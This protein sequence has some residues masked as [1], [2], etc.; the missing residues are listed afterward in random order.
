MLKKASKKGIRKLVR[1]L[2]IKNF[3]CVR[4]LRRGLATTDEGEIDY[5]APNDLAETKEEQRQKVPD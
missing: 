5:P 4:L 1:H 2:V 3:K